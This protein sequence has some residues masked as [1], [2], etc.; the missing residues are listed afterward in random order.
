MS[1]IGEIAL[2]FTFIRDQ[3][4]FYH[5]T[6]KTY[7]RHVASDSFVN[8]LSSKMDKFIEVMQGTENKRLT[9]SKNSKLS[10]KVESDSSITGFLNDFK[11]WLTTELPTYLNKKDTDLF[12]IRDEILADVNQTLYLFSLS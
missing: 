4:K 5:W 11:N 12:N 2:Y 1:N 7:S 6:T 3:I 10:F 8:N 9:L